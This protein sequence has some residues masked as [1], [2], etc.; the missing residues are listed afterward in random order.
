MDTLSADLSDLDR[1]DVP[2]VLSA[3]GSTSLVPLGLRDGAKPARR[4]PRL[5]V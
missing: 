4:L 2:A 1:G 3:R 5:R